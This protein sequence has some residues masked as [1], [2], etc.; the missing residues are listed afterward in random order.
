MRMEDLSLSDPAIRGGH[1]TVNETVDEPVVAQEIT[2][3]PVADGMCL[4]YWLQGVRNNALLNHRTKADLPRTAEIV[5]I[6][7]GVG[8]P[9]H[10]KLMPRCRGL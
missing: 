1:E 8:P 9:S 4:S 2:G 6:G 5:I 7:S 3:L 10:A